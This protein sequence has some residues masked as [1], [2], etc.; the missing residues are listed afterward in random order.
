LA[1]ARQAALGGI[2]TTADDE[3]RRD[4]EAGGEVHDTVKNSI[5]NVR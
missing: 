2:R 5:S 1:A 3:H 4:D